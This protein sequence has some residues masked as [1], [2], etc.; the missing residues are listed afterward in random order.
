[1]YVRGIM[2]LPREDLVMGKGL[3]K[4]MKGQCPSRDMATAW[5][6]RIFK[7][8]VTLARL[9]KIKKNASRK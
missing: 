2:I 1:M 5:E 3:K 9:T 8:R 7:A 6:L 4:L